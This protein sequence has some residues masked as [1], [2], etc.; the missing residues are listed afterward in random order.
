MSKHQRECVRICQRAGLV[1]LGI[2]FGGK[3]LKVVCEQGTIVCP[4][5][6]SDCR[7]KQQMRALC[8]QIAN[9]N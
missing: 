6:P 2:R 1:V 7:W 3:H 4:C 5:T 8:R 9:D